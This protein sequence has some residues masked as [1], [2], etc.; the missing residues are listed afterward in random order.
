MANGIE[1]RGLSRR[2]GAVQ[3]VADLDLMVGAGEIVG[4]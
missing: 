3:A 2:L 1:V 4:L